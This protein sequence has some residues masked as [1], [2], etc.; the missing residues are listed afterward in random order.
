MSAIGNE[1]N[2]TI[3][4]P[5]PVDVMSAFVGGDAKKK[6]GSK[7]PSPEENEGGSP[8]ESRDQ[9]QWKKFDLSFGLRFPTWGKRSI[10]GVIFDI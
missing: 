3:I 2:T 6:K 1:K 7:S 10:F 5:V 8:E 4:F 9:I